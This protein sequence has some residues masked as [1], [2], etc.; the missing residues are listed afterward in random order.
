[1]PLDFG[2]KKHNTRNHLKNVLHLRKLAMLFHEKITCNSV[3]R[4]PV[5]FDPLENQTEELRG[6]YLCHI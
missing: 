4:K 3:F 2:K 1:M 5:N 6:G